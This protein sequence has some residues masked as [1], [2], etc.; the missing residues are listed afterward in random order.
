M[1]TDEWILAILRL[2]LGVCF[3]TAFFR[4]DSTP[5]LPINKFL[6]A[7]YLAY[8]LFIPLI[9]FWR[10]R[11]SPLAHAAI[12]FI[13]ILWVTQLTP[14][15]QWPT[16]GLVLFCYV[17]ASSVLRWGFWEAQLTLASYFVLTTAGF[18]LHNPQLLL[19]WVS[20]HG[21]VLFPEALLY[22]CLAFMG[23]LLAESKAARSE[24]AS[25]ARIA[26]W[27][28]SETGL[29]TAVGRVS[30][31]GCQVYAATQVVVVI[32]ERGR[33]R[34]MMFRAVGSQSDIQACELDAAQ[35]QYY[36]FPKPGTSV[37][38]AMK[39]HSMPRRFRCHLL[40]E[41]RLQ[42][43][44]ICGEFPVGFLAAHPFH[45]ML[46]SAIEFK[47][48]YAVHVYVLDPAAFSGGCAGLRS[49]HYS[50]LQIN[51]VIHDLFLVGRL[52]N[53]AQAI[54]SARVARELH[55]GVIQSLSC[56]SMQLEELRI[57]TGSAFARDTDHFARIQE[58][59]HNE[60]ASLRDLTQQ[61]RSQG[62]DSGSLLQF[63]AG[64]A[65][66]FECE[67]GIATQ[68]IPETDEVQL[69]PKTCME[70]VRIVQESLV[71]IRKHSNAKEAHVIL[72][73]QNGNFLLR[74]IDNGRGFGFSGSRTQEEL[75]A[76]GI[77]PVVLME[78]VQSIGGSICIESEE[79]AGTCLEIIFP[80][81]KPLVEDYA[82]FSVN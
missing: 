47:N 28:R 31:E 21:L 51:P 27:L 18:Y 53:K 77:G 13:D 14:L 2:L 39:R 64:M 42:R 41:D 58:S 54:A 50:M 43:S 55:D 63:L 74:I 45:R 44:K 7:S 56:I 78:R 59:I 29:E 25:I 80:A 40:A 71:N 36:Q 17:I 70:V 79:G 32:H 20:Q 57:Q 24:S 72:S 1:R 38:M 46:A 48:D 76:A 22:F 68:F 66:K 60:I 10:P 30:S 67:H 52:K 16:M 12:H 49:L 26:E 5:A 65:T 6:L 75:L 35:Q 61:L 34:S 3:L 4:P 19:H 11:L 9:L 8:A 82:E 33:N 81:R 15:I 37:R 23:G 73:R 69:P 62:I